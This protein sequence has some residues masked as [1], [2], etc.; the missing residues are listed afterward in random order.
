VDILLFE[1]IVNR[2]QGRR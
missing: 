1:L 2:G